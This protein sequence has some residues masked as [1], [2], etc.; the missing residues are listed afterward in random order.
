[1]DKW[2]Q[3]G[4]V[5][6]GTAGGGA[7]LGQTGTGKINWDND[8]RWK[9]STVN[10][11]LRAGDQPGAPGPVCYWLRA[12]WGNGLSGGTA[13][14]KLFPGLGASTIFGGY[15]AAG[16]EYTLDV[17]R[18]MVR[19]LSFK[20]V[21]E[22]EVTVKATFLVD[23]PTLFGT[24]DIIPPGVPPRLRTLH[25]QPRGTLPHQMGEM[26]THEIEI[27]EPPPGAVTPADPEWLLGL[28]PKPRYWIP[29]WLRTRPLG[30][31]P[32]NPPPRPPRPP[33]Y[34]EE[35][36]DWVGWPWWYEWE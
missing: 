13:V 19:G 8:D 32:W 31:R 17:G 20:P 36:A 35:W 26:E 24:G 34:A 4:N 21:G 15:F 10:P 3:M 29:E 28:A 16:T 6:D 5:T 7:P 11:E 27:P 12:S 14:S 1:G 9:P 22:T 33:R 25:V 23:E 30:P 2:T 18:Y